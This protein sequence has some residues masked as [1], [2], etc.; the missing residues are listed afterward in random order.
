MGKFLQKRTVMNF[1]ILLILIL[2]LKLA[3]PARILV[4]FPTPAYSHY[5]KIIPIIHELLNRNHEIVYVTTE[6]LNHP[7]ANLTEI[8]L[9]Q[10]RKSVDRE[11]WI[12][13]VE[14]TEGFSQFKLV[15]IFKNVAL[16]ITEE[17]F[18]KNE[19]IRFLKNKTFDLVVAEAQF[20]PGLMGF[21]KYFKTP[22]IAFT[23]IKLGKFASSN[24]IRSNR[25]KHASLW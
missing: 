25:E 1:K 22:V 17:I 14:N 13:A 18:K 5:I 3:L 16:S 24:K 19:E 11:F 23:P 10:V 4:I 15:E 6:R 2:Q 8:N 20:V 12:N 9:V 21:G 7:S